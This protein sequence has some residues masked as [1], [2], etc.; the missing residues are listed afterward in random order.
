MNTC[1]VVSVA[2]GIWR[3]LLIDETLDA[4]VSNV[5]DGEDAKQF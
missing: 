1:A 2:N 3:Q 4:T 5:S